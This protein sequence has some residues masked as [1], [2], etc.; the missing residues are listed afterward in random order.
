MNQKANAPKSPDF[1]AAPKKGAGVRRLNRVPLL[2]VGTLVL[3]AVGVVTY[4]FFQRQAQSN[5]KAAAVGPPPVESTAKP[6]VRP[7]AADYVE[8]TPPS[9]PPGMPTDVV[10]AAGNELAV[11]AEAA[12]EH[13]AGPSEAYEN[14][15]RLIQRVEEQRMMRTEAALTAEPAVQ[16]FKKDSG[17]GAAVSSAIA[18]DPMSQMMAQY[19]AAANSAG[20]MGQMGA[21][22][23]AGDPGAMGGGGGA[24]DPNGQAAKRAFLAQQQSA[25]DPYLGHTR[26]PAVSPQQEV[27]AGTIIPGVLM[28]GI[29]SDLPGQIMGQVREN[30]YDTAT[31]RN[32][33]IPAGARLIGTYDNG[34]TFGQSR[35]LVTWSRVIYPDGSSVNLNS[36]PGADMRGY[37]GFDD[38]VNN[39][40]WRVFGHGLLVSMFSAGV[41]LS[42]PQ[43]NSGDGY[44]AQQIMA[45]ELGRQMG[46]LGIEMAR[47]NM[48]IQPTIEIR[49]GY[50]FNVMV[51]KDIVL[52]T[53]HGHPMA[54]RR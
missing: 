7:S 45:A 14:R 24:V 42:V 23:F 11:P 53:W 9:M 17:S 19:A 44:D 15:M 46:Q 41:Q 4:T 10:A 16:A 48:D 39:H 43:K 3:M 26:Q 30:V 35:A 33:L 28:S 50:R 51:T 1:L 36:M 31:G 13:P 40:Y 38:K 6:P 2:V 47:K 34:V 21:P 18:A 49:P 52:P 32:L 27:K 25:D 12:A 22:S 5:A 20:A 29:N 8:A 54:P 37:A